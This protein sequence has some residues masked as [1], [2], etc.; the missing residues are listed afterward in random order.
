LLC[1]SGVAAAHDIRAMRKLYL[2][3]NYSILLILATF[4]AIFSELDIINS[5]PALIVP[6]CRN[7]DEPGIATFSNFHIF[8]LNFANITRF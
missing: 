8:L 4:K 6:H 7:C 5:L 3:D 2:T 1:P